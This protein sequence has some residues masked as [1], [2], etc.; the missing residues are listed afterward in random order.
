MVGAKL[1]RKFR[2]FLACRRGYFRLPESSLDRIELKF[3]GRRDAEICAGAAHRPEQ[4]GMFA[5]VHR[6]RRAARSG[7]MARDRVQLP[8]RGR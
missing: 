5:R 4:I 2:I 7:G 6:D 8:S 1:S 3:E